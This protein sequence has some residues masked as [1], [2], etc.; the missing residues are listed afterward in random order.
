MKRESQ[1]LT[2]FNLT[3]DESWGLGG[4]SVASATRDAESGSCS[5]TPA[6]FR[7]GK[8]SQTSETCDDW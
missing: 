2:H 7:G 8:V 1:F 4:E 5:T 6:R 3:S